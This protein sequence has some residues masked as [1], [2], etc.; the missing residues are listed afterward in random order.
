MS[1]QVDKLQQL[2]EMRQKARLGGGEARIEK[3]HAKGKMT[4]RE[5]IDQLLDKG[6]FEEIDMFVELRSTNFGMD[7]KKVLG[8]GVV[9]GCGTIDGRLVYVFAQDFTAIAGSLGEMHAAKICKI[10][11]M[12]MRVGAPVLGIND[13]GGARIQ[14]G[15]NALSGYAEIFERNIPISYT[16]L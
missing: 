5:R 6:S 14:E 2:I 12:A 15:V 10:Q 4:A 9:T 3:Q 11:D 7:K 16:H 1:T 13:S 8:D